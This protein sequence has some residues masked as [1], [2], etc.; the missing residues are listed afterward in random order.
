MRTMRAVLLA[1]LV[2]CQP[3]VDAGTSPAA[4]PAATTAGCPAPTLLFLNFTGQEV[5]G[6]R[7]PQC[8]DVE[9]DA[10]R[11]CSSSIRFERAYVP[12]YWGTNVASIVLDVRRRFRGYN[13]Q[14]VTARPAAGPY[15]MVIVGGDPSVVGDSG[16]EQGGEAPLG[17]CGRPARV[18]YAFGNARGSG[19]S[20]FDDP[21]Q[22]GITIAHEAGHMFGLSHVDDRAD[23]MYPVGNPESVFQSV[24][25]P[26]HSG[27][28]G[29]PGMAR[30][31]AQNDSQQLLQVLGPGCGPT[32]APLEDK[33][34]PP[35]VP[36][37][38]LTT[39]GTGSSSA[40][41]RSMDVVGGCVTVPASRA[42]AP[43]VILALVVALL[44]GAS[45]SRRCARSAAP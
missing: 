30:P 39:N 17:G 32:A 20:N 4:A 15:L 22:G 7:T 43:I 40:T 10:A 2:G 25:R 44:A 11:N 34:A 24:T 21:L 37:E 27:A 8:A 42:P 12:A 26:I 13:L 35:P 29:C 14:V 38:T 28:R 36:A 16:G 45:C 31:T 9:D 3:V 6:Y 18:G 1:C 41:P 5:F 23:T 19:K 33:V